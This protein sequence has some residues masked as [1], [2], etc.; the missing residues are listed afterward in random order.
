MNPKSCAE[1]P[2]GK[3]ASARRSGRKRALGKRVPT[4][5]L[6]NPNQRWRLDFASD[7]LTDGRRIRILIVLGSPNH[8]L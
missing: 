3:L 2:R 8:L 4:A 1:L 5:V 6:Q 7:A